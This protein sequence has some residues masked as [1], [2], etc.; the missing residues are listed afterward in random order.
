MRSTCLAST[1][2]PPSSRL[3][4]LDSSTLTIAAA[5]PAM[6]VTAGES[7]ASCNPKARS[8]GQKPLSQAS[9]S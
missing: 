3:S 4:S 8:R 5:S 2:T 7:D 9:Q 6:R 1:G